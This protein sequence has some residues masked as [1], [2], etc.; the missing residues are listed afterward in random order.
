MLLFC[1]NFFI[2]FYFI[3]SSFAAI[4]NIFVHLYGWCM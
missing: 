4:F 2:L 3:L 1:A